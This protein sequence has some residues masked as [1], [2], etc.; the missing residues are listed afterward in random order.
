MKVFKRSTIFEQ[1]NIFKKGAEII[2]Q[3]YKDVITGLQE[4]GAAKAFASVCADIIVAFINESEENI[5][6]T[7][8]NASHRKFRSGRSK[9]T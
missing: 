1:V 4:T 5:Q 3:R 7:A 6:R 8:Y 2:E 9:C